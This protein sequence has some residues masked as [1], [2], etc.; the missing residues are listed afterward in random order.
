[1]NRKPPLA[2]WLWLTL[3]AATH[4]FGAGRELIADNHFQRGFILW[5]PKPG[6]HVRYGELKGFTNE[7]PVW[8]LCQWSSKFPLSTNVSAHTTSDLVSSNAAKLVRVGRDGRLV[9]AVNSAV[10]YGGKAR[11]WSEPWVHLLVEQSFPAP[12]ALSA[13]SAAD[14]HIEAR[15][16]RSTNLHQGDYSPSRHA[17]QFQLFFTVQ[18]S[19]RSSRGH[20][21]LVWFGV[22]IFDSR[23]R[24][25]KAYKARDFGGTEKFIFT[26]GGETYAAK[27]THDGEWVAIDRD[28]RPLMIDALNT[29]WTQGFLKGSTNIADY[30]I[31]GMNMGWELPGTFDVS[32]EIRALSLTATAKDK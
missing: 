12:A 13:I 18:N 11:R 27:S 32:L 26:P 16:L 23:E 6:A 14:L 10:E 1:M 8:G 19:N 22:P 20:G 9:L 24:F 28:L 15:L 31:T 3:V 17:A 30:S 2:L 21:D 29:A 7:A 4:V 25:P 5:E